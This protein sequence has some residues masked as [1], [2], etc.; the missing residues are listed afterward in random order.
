MVKRTSFIPTKEQLLKEWLQWIINNL[1][2]HG[3]TI[4]LT[5][6]EINDIKTWC[7]QV[8]LKIDEAATAKTAFK[9]AVTA[10][11]TIKT[12]NLPKISDMFVAAKLHKDF[13][14]TIGDALRLFGTEHDHSGDNPVLESELVQTGWAIK[15]NLQGGVFSGINLY[16]KR[17][18]ETE[19]TKLAFD[20]ATPYIDTETQVS[21]TQYFASYVDANDEEVN[22][23]GDIITVKV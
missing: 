2:T 21:G 20:S 11:R 9:S 22:S 1:S 5:P 10:K 16:R 14:K 12:D 18:S 13:T 19:F 15:F 6:G 17:P 7:Q 4:G 8:I 3:A 23:D